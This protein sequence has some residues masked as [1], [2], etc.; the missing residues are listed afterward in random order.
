MINK[1]DYQLHEKDTGSTSVQI[2][3]LNTQIQQLIE[4]GNRNRKVNF[5]EKRKKERWKDVPA[6]R[7]LLKKIAKKK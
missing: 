7:A 1:K 3:S 6:K 4:H 2:V 5:N